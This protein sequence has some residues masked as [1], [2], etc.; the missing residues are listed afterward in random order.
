MNQLNGVKTTVSYTHA[1]E[2]GCEVKNESKLNFQVF[3]ERVTR[4]S[5]SLCAK[6]QLSVGTRVRRHNELAKRGR[7]R[8]LLLF[9]EINP[10]PSVGAGLNP[11]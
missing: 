1:L 6:L 10:R 2:G 4:R 11:G 7:E 5:F 8:A 9:G 3:V